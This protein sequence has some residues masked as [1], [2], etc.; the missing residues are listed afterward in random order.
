[1]TVNASCGCVEL[2]EAGEFMELRTAGV[3]LVRTGP[4]SLLLETTTGFCLDIQS[5][6]PIT[7][8]SREMAG[9]WSKKLTASSG[10]A[11][12]G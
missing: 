7:A 8:S 12:E 2:D 3:R 6:A 1:M 5:P 4:G 9:D 11:A 10:S